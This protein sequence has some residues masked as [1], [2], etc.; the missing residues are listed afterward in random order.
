M[1]KEFIEFKGNIPANVSKDASYSIKRNKHGEYVIGLVYRSVDE[2]IWYP[3]TDEHGE[4]VDKINEIKLYFS[5][6]PGGK[7]YINEYSQV[8]VPAADSKYYY[9]G[10]YHNPI[11]FEFEGK[12][13]SG[14]AIDFDGK[15]LQAGDIW[16]GPHA[17]IPYILN[18]GGKDITYRY[19]PRENVIIEKKLSREVGKTVALSVAKEIAIIKGNNGGRFYVN[20]YKN[21][22]APIHSEYGNDYIY[23]GKLNLDNWFPKPNMDKV[24]ETEGVV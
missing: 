7:F 3:S 17:G 1:S 11:F 20:E 18:A 16:V 14:E 8:L 6:S 24:C 22:F 15:Q 5:G 12:K 4:L 23:V 10:E 21:I 2:E 13:I 19:S 9:A